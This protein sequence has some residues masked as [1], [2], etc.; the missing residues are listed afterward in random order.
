M[1]IDAGIFT[2]KMNTKTM[3]TDN[4]IYKAYI[5][6]YNDWHH[7]ADSLQEMWLPVTWDGVI[8]VE[9]PGTRTYLGGRV[10]LWGC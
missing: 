4:D 10:N 5:G 9:G 3:S 8:L 6:D 7:N 1:F 2:A